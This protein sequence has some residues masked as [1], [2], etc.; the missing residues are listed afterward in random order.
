[1]RKSLQIK[2]R[3]DIGSGRG[4]LTLLRAMGVFGDRIHP[5]AVADVPAGGSGGMR[6]TQS[7]DPFR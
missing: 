2:A 6:G 5:L 4:S 3:P 7:T 1:M